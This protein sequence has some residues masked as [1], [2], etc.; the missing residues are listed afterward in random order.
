MKWT[1]WGMVLLALLPI[2]PATRAMATAQA[3]DIIVID[4]KEY[5]LNTNPLDRYLSKLGD[6]APRFEPSSSALWRGYIASWEL[7]GGKLFLRKI[8]VP[9]YG[10]SGD[11]KKPSDALRKV[12]PG[13]GEVVADWYSGALI[14]PDG[15]LVQYVHMGYGSTY[16]RYIVSLI[17]NGEEKRRLRLSEQEFRQFRDSQFLKF[18]AGSAYQAMFDQLKSRQSEGD[19]MYSLSDEEIEQFI[20]EFSAEEYL[21]L[22]ENEGMAGMETDR[23]SLD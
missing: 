15:K 2:L 23:Q 8:S 7:E 22:M 14:I 1:H 16:E 10:R 18:K 6:V 13:E 9:R 21:S 20:R 3:P 11:E 5:G 12:F 17:R 19:D 4:G